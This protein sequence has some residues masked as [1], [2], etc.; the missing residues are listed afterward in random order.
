MTYEINL[1][2]LIQ[3]FGNEENCRD[4]LESLRWPDGMTCPHCKSKA[5]SEVHVRNKF[6]CNTCRYQFSVTS[7]TIMH[8]THLPLTKWFLAVYMIVES[9]K[10][11]SA[12]QLSRTLDISYR[13]SWYLCHRIRKALYT[14][15]ALMMGI[16]E[17]DET[18]I[19]GKADKSRAGGRRAGNKSIVAGVVERGGDLRMQVVPDTKRMTLR[20]FIR[21]HVRHSAEG[22]FT[23]DWV[24]YKGLD[25]EYRH[26]T[27]NHSAEEWTRGDVHTNTVEN[28][29]G[30]FKRCV[31]GAYHKIS[32]K[33]LDLYLDEFEFRFN[34][35]DNPY[36]F[37]DAI[38]ELLTAESMQYAELVA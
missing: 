5:I 33:H 4:Y 24:S 21:E 6:D 17:V 30:L 16:C 12:N 37:R 8:D 10:S 29:W 11:V 26:A 15:H 38:K 7:G 27:V 2:N 25:K 32:K 31:I 20:E 3:K 28:A 23:D 22:L 19:G 34:N 9:K 1:I 35:R 36:I 18:W 14:P 13:T